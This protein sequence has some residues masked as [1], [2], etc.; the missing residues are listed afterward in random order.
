MSASATL[1]PPG[2]ASLAAL[3]L[4]LAGAA[5]AALAPALYWNLLEAAA[6]LG[7]TVLVWRHTEA[8]S[9]VWVVLSA[10]TLEMTLLDLVGPEA[11]QATIAATKAAGLALALLCV[12][13]YG[14][15]LDLHN[16]AWG[17]LLIFVAGLAHGLHPGL[18]P[19]DSLRSL[20]GSVAPYGFTFSR[21]SRRWATAIIRATQWAP[22]LSVAGGICLALAGLRPLFVDSGGL[23][24]EALGHPAFLA[25]AALT[26]VYASLIEAYRN[27]GK[28]DLALLVANGVILLLTGAR[29]PLLYGI[30]VVVL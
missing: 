17:F 23:R 13:R 4:M 15:R 27:R 5:C 29:A 19:A 22:M 3:G 8:A 7:L 18:T 30:A 12:L 16:P 10:C 6:V 1:R 20:F 26:A 25:G 28:R 21:L 9:V 14:P 11:Y 2:P 24:L